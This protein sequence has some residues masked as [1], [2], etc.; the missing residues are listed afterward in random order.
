LGL[1]GGRGGLFFVP[2]EKDLL[3]SSYVMAV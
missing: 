1:A 3:H 2:S